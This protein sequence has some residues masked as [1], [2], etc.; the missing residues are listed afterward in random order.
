MVKPVIFSVDDEPHV[1]GAIARDLQAHYRQDFRIVRAGSGAEA[2][3]AAQELKRRGTPVALFLVDQ[4][5]PGMSGTEFLE[6]AIALYPDAKRVLLTAYADT[7][8][9]I[10]S[11]NTIDLDYYLLK[12]WDP[13]EERLYPVLD[14]LLG[15]WRANVPVGYDGIRVAGTLWS[16]ASH[17]VK[18]FLARGQIPYQWLDIEKDAQAAAMVDASSGEQVRLPVIFF[19]DGT[20]LADPP[21]AQLA[22]K[23]GLR[24]PA[25]QP[26]YDLIVVGA[27]PAGLAA[28]VYGASEGLRT[29]VIEREVAG[30]QA[31]TSSR[32]ENYLGFPN[33]ISGADLARRAATQAKRLGAELLAAVEVTAVRVDGDY[34]IITLD[35]GTELRCHALV[36]ATGVKVRT[37]DVPGAER[38]Q[39]A[40]LYY[41]A[42]ASEAAAYAGRHVMVVGGANS[43][44]QGA[45]FL[46][47]YAAQVDILVRG[48]SLAHSM[49]RYLIDQI[50]AVP[51]IAVRPH[52]QVRELIGDDHLERVRLKDART[53]EETEE[54]A[55]AMFVFIGAV[56]CTAIVD[57]LVET[58]DGFVVTGQD[59]IR[60]GRRPRGWAPA[61][62][63]FLL[64]TSVPG[65]FAAGDVRHDVMRR[66]ASAVGEGAVAVSLVHKYLQTV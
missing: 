12:P 45:M 39:G 55:D 54:D 15:D 16:P 28:G 44:G 41:G 66:V 25:Q 20:T 52:I 31:G 65:I 6:R 49:S 4:R 61:R 2:L 48:D 21:L 18:D 17:A 56:P 24:A 32:I 58:Q 60:E 8:A 23:V 33:G 40:S 50:E 7:D 53:G 62:D 10:A 42:A 36:L 51:N 3:E 14:E 46:S 19:P 5:M 57:G 34:K 22:E 64:E 38:L 43:A 37:L 1:L 27:G 30:G 59:L 13:P 35:D 29:V 63:P 11:I 26:F 9:A 47:R